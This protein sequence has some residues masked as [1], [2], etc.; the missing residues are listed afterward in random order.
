MCW[1]RLRRDY[2][3]LKYLLGKLRVRSFWEDLK[4]NCKTIPKWTNVPVQKN[5]DGINT[6]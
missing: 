1:E 3:C 4:V 2:K 5:V 6:L